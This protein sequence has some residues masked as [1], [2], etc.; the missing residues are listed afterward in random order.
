MPGK[1]T[2]E[3][4]PMTAHESPRPSRRAL[5]RAAGVAV[6]L[7][8]L[9]ALGS[10]GRA[11]AAETE[12]PHRMV[13]IETTM[14]LLPQYY[15]PAGEGRD[16]V[17][18]PYLAPLEP[19]RDR[20]TVFSGLSHPQVDGGHAADVAF[21]TGAAHPASGSFRNSVSLDQLA[22]ESIGDRTRIPALPLTV[23]ARGTTSLSFTRDGVLVPGERSPA[24]LYRQMFLQGSPEETA[25]KVESLRAGRSVLDFV[26]S[27]ARRL[28]KTLPA[29][30]RGRLDQYFTS[31]RELEE[32]LK[33]A[34]VW[35]KRRR[36]RPKS[37]APPENPQQELFTLLRL[38]GEMIRL[39]LESD[40]TRLVT[41]FVNPAQWVPRAP[42]VVH[43]T[44]S[45][46]HHGNRPEMIAELKRV[47][48]LQFVVLG[49]LLAGLDGVRE[50]PHTLLD[51]TIVLHGSCMGNANAHSNTRLPVL[52]AG[53]GFRHAGHLAF[54]DGDG[55][56]LANLYVSILQRMGI[57]TDRFASSTG[58]L[59]GLEPA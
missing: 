36:P 53:G 9:E 55:P 18:S 48:E 3:G 39:A 47:E 50:G 28:D 23:A 54:A 16:Y 6:G 37:P 22:A 45:L 32:R 34:E 1:S 59:R 56:P 10:R 29:A 43:E 26:A 41:L 2:N 31:V 7:P 42:G 30:D 52:V 27:G 4:E 8:W 5:L 40:T 33:R 38:M 15:F 17:A 58:T 25:G 21:L 12:R 51:R 20:L 57:E 13:A 14:G 11:A 19:F 35:E 49:E 46:T 44:H 24:R